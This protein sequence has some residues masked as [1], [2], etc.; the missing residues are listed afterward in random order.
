MRKD[1]KELILEYK[2]ARFSLRVIYFLDDKK[3]G[4][5][6]N[7]HCLPRAQ[8]SGKMQ[9]CDHVRVSTNGLRRKAFMEGCNPPRTIATPL[10]CHMFWSSPFP[11]QSRKTKLIRHPCSNSLVIPPCCSVTYLLAPLDF[12]LFSANIHTGEK[13]IFHFLMQRYLACPFQCKQ[14]TQLWASL[15]WAKIWTKF[16]NCYLPD[17][18]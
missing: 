8:S 10:E 12:I 18:Q 7:V 17:P 16:Q 9:R 13:L 3:S 15:C 4:E 5:F 1:A 6:L 14:P 11:S 2:R